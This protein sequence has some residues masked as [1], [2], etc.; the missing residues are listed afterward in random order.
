M[1]YTPGRATERSDEKATTLT[2]AARTSGATPATEPENNGP[3]TSLA[4]SASAVPAARAAPS[5]VPWVSRGSNTK[6]S[7]PTSNSAIWAASKSAAP[8][9]ADG[10]DKGS[11]RATDTGPGGNA[12]AGA[13][14]AGASGSTGTT[15]AVP[16][17]SNASSSEGSDT[18]GSGA[19]GGGCGAVTAAAGGA[20]VSTVAVRDKYALVLAPRQ[21]EEHGENADHDPTTRQQRQ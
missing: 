17:G 4:P 10:P 2:P 16:T 9:S 6:S 3:S 13:S 7:F 20:V 11:S 19:A 8:S 18:A 12:I 1:R 15:P 5:G 21:H 14:T